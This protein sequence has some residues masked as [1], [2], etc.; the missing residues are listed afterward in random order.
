[1]GIRYLRYL[2]VVLGDLLIAHLSHP[3]NPM[4]FLE[5]QGPHGSYRLQRRLDISLDIRKTGCILRNAFKI[6]PLCKKKEKALMTFAAMKFQSGPLACLVFIV[7]WGFTMPE[8]ASAGSPQPQQQQRRGSCRS[9]WFVFLWICLSSFIIR[10]RAR[11]T[12][13]LLCVWLH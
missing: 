3:S 11:G 4:I 2:S 5:Q 10:L 12:G 9:R 8:A 7:R 13:N 6:A 1:M